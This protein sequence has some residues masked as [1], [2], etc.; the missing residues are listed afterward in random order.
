ML[1]SNFLAKKSKITKTRRPVEKLEDFPFEEE[2]LLAKEAVCAD[3]SA[4]N[5]HPKSE[6]INPQPQDILPLNTL[7]VGARVHELTKDIA[8]PL[9]IVQVR[10]EIDMLLKLYEEEKHICKEPKMTDAEKLGRVIFYLSTI[11]FHSSDARH[12]ILKSIK[13]MEDKNNKLFTK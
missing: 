8:P 1:S 7:Q 6:F 3:I 4:R 13:T 5:E 12:R 2:E 9:N 11:C 10:N